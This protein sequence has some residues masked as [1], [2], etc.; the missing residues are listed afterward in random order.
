ML[1]MGARNNREHFLDHEPD[2]NIFI[3]T[4]DGSLGIAGNVID[5][6]K[7]IFASKKIVENTKIFSCGPPR[8]MES[9]RLYAIENKIPCD[10]ALE[11]IMACGI[12]ICQGCAIEK[13]APDSNIH[14]YE[15]NFL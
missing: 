1:I 7:F 11:T 9:V 13:H 12:G 10:L 2:K 5:A 4:D 14:S 3:S 15:I 6:I 8:M